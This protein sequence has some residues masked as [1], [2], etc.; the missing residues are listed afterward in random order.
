MNVVFCGTGAFGVPALHALV[1]AG[2]RPSL[3]VTQPDRPA[4]RKRELK[5]SP[6]K[7][8]ALALGLELFQP[9]KIN[10]EEALSR[11][12]AEAPD[13]LIVVAYGQILRRAVLDLPR[14]GCVNLHGSLL[15]RHRGA[16]PI[17]AAL[18]AGDAVA[19]VAAMLMDEGLDTGPVLGVVS[20]AVRPDD[21]AGTLHD[22]LAALGAPLLVRTLDELAAGAARPV[23]QD[24]ARATVCRTLSRDD[25]RL[26]WTK[27]APELERLV[28]AMRP[29][30]GAWTVA[31]RGDA[32]P[33]EIGVLRAAVAPGNA[34]AGA[35]PGTVV[36][37][38]NDGVDVATGDGLLRLLSVKP[39]GKNAMDASAFGRGR[40]A[41][42]GD[43]WR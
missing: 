20:D 10:R 22:R 28:R 9:E 38:G 17:A 18:A 35:P 24:D 36:A 13:V 7:E 26:P 3:V 16:S 12:R 2:K 6:I 19:G 11:L 41:V 21:D 43:V 8:A 25:A 39:A 42:P 4:G 1:A 27:P 33:A 5:P 23:P 30:P 37:V 34:P 31:V 32:P 29:W 14:L 40:G 15:P